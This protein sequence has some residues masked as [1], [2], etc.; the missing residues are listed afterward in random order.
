MDEFV[1]L[2]NSGD[3]RQHSEFID[4]PGSLYIA[5]FP[6]FP[7][8]QMAGL[9]RISI[10]EADWTDPNASLTNERTWAWM[11]VSTTGVFRSTSQTLIRISSSGPIRVV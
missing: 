11:S 9:G 5:V 1:G 2:H 3:R 4:G 10:L 6:E 7:R 8:E